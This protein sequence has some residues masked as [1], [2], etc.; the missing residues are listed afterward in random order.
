MKKEIKMKGMTR[1]MRMASLAVCAVMLLV[2]LPVRLIIRIR[3]P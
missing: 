1:I 2:M 3:R